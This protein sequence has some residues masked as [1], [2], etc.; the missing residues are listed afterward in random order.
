MNETPENPTPE[1]T[2]H[3]ERLRAIEGLKAIID[4]GERIEFRAQLESPSREFYWVTVHYRVA[5]ISV[6]VGNATGLPLDLGRF[7]N[8]I[9]EILDKL[10]ELGIKIDNYDIVEVNGDEL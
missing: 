6:L 10:A 4:P 5:D 9:Q 3:R 7:R 8:S 1:A 2:L